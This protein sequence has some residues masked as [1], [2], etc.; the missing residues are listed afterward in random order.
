[1]HDSPRRSEASGA[2]RRI[3]EP[4]VFNRQARLRFVK[5]RARHL[6]EHLGREPSYPERLVIARIAADEWFL[7][8]SDARLERDG[9]L[10]APAMQA[11]TA[12]EVRVRRDLKALGK[13]AAPRAPTLAEL[14]AEIIARESA[15]AARAPLAPVG[16][17]PAPPDAEPA[18]AAFLGA[19]GP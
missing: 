14:T 10:S 18:C 7:R 15:A 5:D 16:R 3:R 9:E 11:R 19:S 1:M 6:V 8:L 12:A 4:Q 2:L 17:T 13:P